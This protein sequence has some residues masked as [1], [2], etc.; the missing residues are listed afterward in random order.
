[1]PYSI[2]IIKTLWA[3]SPWDA[4]YVLPGRAAKSLEEHERI[5]TAIA[6]QDAKG[7]GQRVQ[8]HIDYAASALADY[9]D[10][11]SKSVEVLLINTPS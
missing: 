3:Q 7:A 5:L 4:L 10:N 2:K 8:D 11:L 9:I 1:M 6:E